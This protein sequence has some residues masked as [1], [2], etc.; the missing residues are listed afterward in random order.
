MVRRRGGEPGTSRRVCATYALQEVRNLWGC[1]EVSDL[2]GGPIQSLNGDDLAEQ[3]DG[4]QLPEKGVARQHSGV[5]PQDCRGSGL[6]GVV[7]HVVGTRQGDHQIGLEHGGP[8]GNIYKSLGGVR[9]GLTEVVDLDGPPGLLLDAPCQHLNEGL[10]GLRLR[11]EN[12]GVADGKN[13]VGVFEGVGDV[14]VARDVGLRRLQPCPKLEPELQ[15]HDE[16]DHGGQAEGEQTPPADRAT[17]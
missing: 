14:L 9:G 13:P 8:L 2:V 3:S 4:T 7:E 1:S 15:Q 12:P 11:T 5:F 17:G 16:A 10:L 6:V